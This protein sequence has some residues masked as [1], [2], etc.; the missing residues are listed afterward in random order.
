MSSEIV[1]KTPYLIVRNGRFYFD[2][3]VPEDVVGAFKH[4]FK[5]KTGAIRESLKTKD[6]KRALREM[7]EKLSFYSAQF[8]ELRRSGDAEHIL[9]NKVGRGDLSK[10]SRP[11]LE[12]LVVD[13]YRDVLKPVAVSPPIDGEDRDVL[14]EEWTDTF[15]Q[16]CDRRDAKERVQN[17]A[18]YVLL[19][20]GWPSIRTK[21]GAIT[22]HIP[23]VD[24]DRTVEQYGALMDLVRRASIEGSRLAL[25]ELHGKV[26]TTADPLFA[27]GFN[28]GEASDKLGPVLSDALAAWK[29]GSSVRGS[30]KPSD[31]T[32]KE[33]ASFVQRFTELHGDIRVGEITKKRVQEFAA[34]MAAIPAHL[35]TKLSKL[36]LPALLQEDLSKFRPRASGTINKTF[37]LWP[38]AGFVDA[39]LS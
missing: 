25:A 24:V 34:A 8:D 30:R 26:F 17:T 19:K 29:E 5:R 16:M 3:R 31:G 39:Q 21:V 13:F 20:A 35:P 2:M 12:K 6:R 14:V 36:T 9:A 4:K 7:G 1:P 15:N 27:T 28:L 10:L 18:D 23:T 33:A 32:A 37:Q 11:E 22:R 38:A